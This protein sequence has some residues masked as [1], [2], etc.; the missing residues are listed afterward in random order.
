VL[1]PLEAN[2]KVFEYESPGLQDTA[3]KLLPDAL[4]GNIFMPPSR[5]KETRG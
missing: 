5:F 1:Q 2:E 3:R 4:G